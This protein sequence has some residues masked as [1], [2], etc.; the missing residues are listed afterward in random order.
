MNPYRQHEETKV[1][2]PKSGELVYRPQERNDRM[3]AG[4]SGFRL[5]ALPTL[6][7]GIAGVAAGP[8]AAS[9]VFVVLLGGLLWRQRKRPEHVVV[10]RVDRGE[11]CVLAFGSDREM[12]RVRLDDLDDVVLETKA[13]ERLMD[14]SAGAVNIGM[15][16]INPSIAVPTE[17]KRI[18]LETSE[19]ETHALT[20]EFFGHSETTEW[21]AKI[22]RFLRSVGWTPLAERSEDEDVF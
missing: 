18:V 7:G 3:S 19:D 20:T 16:A 6:A 17:T 12:F 21:F 8:T 10:L 5:L 22:R 9:A 2:E 13:V 11:L 4:R 15:G 14:T 1:P